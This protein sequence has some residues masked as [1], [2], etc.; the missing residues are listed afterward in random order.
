VHIV[1][2]GDVVSPGSA[3]SAHV[4]ECWMLECVHESLTRGFGLVL[5]WFW[6]VWFGLMWFGLV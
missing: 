4:V 2:D 1:R 5:V 3:G 6:V